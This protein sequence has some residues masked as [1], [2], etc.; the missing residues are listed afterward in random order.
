MYFWRYN[1]LVTGFRILP[2][3]MASAANIEKHHLIGQ[4]MQWSSHIQIIVSPFSHQWSVGDGES[5]ANALTY[6]W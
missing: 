6:F 3:K 4:E 5:I 1:E 2:V